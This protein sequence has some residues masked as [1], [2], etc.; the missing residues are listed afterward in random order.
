MTNWIVHQ[1][2]NNREPSYIFDL[3]ARPRTYQP[4]IDPLTTGLGDT[5]M[6]VLGSRANGKQHISLF[7]GLCTTPQ[8]DQCLPP[9]PSIFL[10]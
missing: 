5:L 8:V 10:V 6:V 1:K 2:I 7:V 9:S 4:A 3:F